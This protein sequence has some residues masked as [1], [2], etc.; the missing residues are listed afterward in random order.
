MTSAALRTGQSPA[1]GRIL[2]VARARIRY[3]I[4]SRVAFVAFA[5]AV[6]PWFAIDQHGADSELGL[7]TGSMLVALLVTG[8]GVVADALDEGWYGIGVLHGLLPLEL[9]VGEALGAVVGLLPVVAGFAL[10]SR[11]AFQEV[12]FLA[13]VLCLAWLAALM[14]G[15]LSI[16]LFLG[17]LLPGKG[18]AIGMI[19]LLL[20]FAFPSDALPLDSWPP[21]LSRGARAAWDAM[22]LESHATAMYAAL[23]HDSTPPLAAPVALLLT[24]PSFLLLAALRLSR[25]DA[26]GRITG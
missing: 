25:L 23:L 26:A 8:S 3:L 17:T 5:L 1:L 19:P 15:W 10:L 2:C 9:L 16:L 24:P 21:A 12:P 18:N 13:L 6:L 14:L 11:H 7:L 22:P 20:A 4:R